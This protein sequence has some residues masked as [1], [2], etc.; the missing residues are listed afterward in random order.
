MIHAENQRVAGQWFSWSVEMN[1]GP[2]CSLIKLSR[3]R[4]TGTA[5]LAGIPAPSPIAP[6]T[7]SSCLRFPATLTELLVRSFLSMTLLRSHSC[8]GHVWICPLVVRLQSEER[9]VAITMTFL[10]PENPLRFSS[11]S[12]YFT[13]V[14]MYG[15]PTTCTF[16]S[17]CWRNRDGGVLMEGGGRI[18]HE[19]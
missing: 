9:H 7:I 1:P 3:A 19:L 13:P 5:R 15:A 10:Q 16:Q 8:K 12:I 18:K 14:E 17:C 4:Q 6:V 11:F 2:C